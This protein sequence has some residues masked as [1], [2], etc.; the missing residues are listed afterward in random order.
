M[1]G[2]CGRT[3]VLHGCVLQGWPPAAV[4][5]TSWHGSRGPCAWLPAAARCVADTGP[6]SGALHT[7]TGPMHAPEACST[8]AAPHTSR[9]APA[10]RATCTFPHA[11]SQSLPAAVSASTHQLLLRPFLQQPQPCPRHGPLAP[12]PAPGLPPRHAVPTLRPT[13]PP[14][15]WPNAGCTPSALTPLS[16]RFRAPARPAAPR[17]PR[18]PPATALTC[19]PPRLRPAGAAPLG[20]APTALRSPPR[21]QSRP[22]GRR[23]P[24]GPPP[25]G[26][27]LQPLTSQRRDACLCC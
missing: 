26:E 1:C 13:R 7:A 9:D 2:S 22:R 8:A 16:P 5:A 12:A 19:R 11:P 3:D 4:W 14:R 10:T 18:A 17:R 23:G 27:E 6:P 21:P 24:A 15:P 25:G 20:R